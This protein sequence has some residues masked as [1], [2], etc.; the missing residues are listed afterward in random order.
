MVGQERRVQNAD[1]VGQQTVGT[2]GRFFKHRYA[3]NVA[4]PYAALAPG[5]KPSIESIVGTERSVGL[6]VRGTIFCQPNVG[7]ASSGINRFEGTCHAAAGGIG[8]KDVARPC[9]GKELSRRTTPAGDVPHARRQL[10][11]EQG[12]SQTVGG[13]LRLQREV[14]PLGQGK[15]AVGFGF[16]AKE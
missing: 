9:I 12:G 15:Q 6:V 4:A 16:L 8:S 2:E 10:V 14:G 1:K 3:R 5:A 11:G 7:V 13:G